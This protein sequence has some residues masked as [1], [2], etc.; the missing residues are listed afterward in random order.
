MYKMIIVNLEQWRGSPEH[1]AQQAAEF[2]R[3]IEQHTYDVPD[4]DDLPSTGEIFDDVFLFAQRSGFRFTSVFEDYDGYE[5]L[6]VNGTTP[7]LQF[8]LHD[9]SEDEDTPQAAFNERSTSCR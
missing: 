9:M 1:E 7:V 6:V 5:W 4:W 8:Y 3:F 2:A